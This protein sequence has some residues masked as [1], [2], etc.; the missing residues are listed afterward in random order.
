MI[1][2]LKRY[3]YYVLVPIGLLVVAL[4]VLFLLGRGSEDDVAFIYQLF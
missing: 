3:R 2:F 1:A 4:A